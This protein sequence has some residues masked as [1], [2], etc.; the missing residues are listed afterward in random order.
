MFEPNVREL[1]FYQIEAFRFGET[2]S[3]T[4]PD[5]LFFAHSGAKTSKSI[6]K[7]QAAYSSKRVFISQSV[8]ARKSANRNALCKFLTKP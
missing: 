4:Y 6:Q 5:L 3:A 8:E 7:M 1:D 2:R